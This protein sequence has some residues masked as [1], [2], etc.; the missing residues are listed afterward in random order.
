[1]IDYAIIGCGHIA[2]KHIEAIRYAEGA[3]L[4]A[5]C[6]TNPGRLAAMTA[7]EQVTGYT[8]IAEM[9]EKQP[10]IQVVC[11][12]T[13]SGL[14][15]EHAL[16]AANAGK[17]LIIEKPMT[18][19]L[20]DADILIRAASRNQVKTA[21]V[22]PNRFRP[23]V[24]KL[25]T[26]LE[27]EWFGK[28]SHA[29]VSVRWNRSQAYYD[30]AAWRGTK[31]M[32]GGV[33]MNQAIHS[34]DLLQWLMGPVE[35]VKS[36]VDTRIRH[37]EAEDVAVAA[38]RFTNGALGTVE[39]TTAIYEENLEETIGVFGEYGYAVISGKTANWIK[40]WRC[41]SM[42]DEQI[43]A[44]ISE[45]DRDPFGVPGHQI[46]IQDMVHAIKD[47]RDPIVTASDGRQ[48][49]QLVLEI[50]KGKEERLI[51]GSHGGRDLYYGAGIN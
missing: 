43:A 44:W 14:H 23:A 36:L 2:S 50:D 35:C 37:I 30:Q 51:A 7:A 47:N 28:L 39:A 18:L 21:V 45:V 12:C 11:I 19:T 17:H 42:S 48:A 27:H 32:D 25:K 3:Q 31:Q 6:D 16:A 46:I 49:I 4:V 1:M 22:H 24:Q 15:I 26:A 10:S 5:I 33:L 20:E 40:H 8:D 13:P 38:L 41:S 29:S 9:L 34:L